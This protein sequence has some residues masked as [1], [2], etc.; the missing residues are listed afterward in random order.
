MGVLIGGILVGCAG[1]SGEIDDGGRA[2]RQ[3]ENAP[4]DYAAKD[5]V[6]GQTTIQIARQ[7]LEFRRKDAEAASDDEPAPLAK[8][9]VSRYADILGQDIAGVDFRNLPRV[10]RVVPAG[11]MVT[12]DFREERLSIYLDN[13]NVVDRIACE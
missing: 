4:V 8:C 12:Q 3:I 10:Y 5:D 7:P 13:A 1:V 9:D 2:Q 6:F 11:A